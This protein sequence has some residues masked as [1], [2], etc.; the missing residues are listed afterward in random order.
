M[1]RNIH[2]CSSKDYD[3]YKI[4]SLEELITKYDEITKN[5]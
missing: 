4:S 3:Y 2:K 1:V 5:L